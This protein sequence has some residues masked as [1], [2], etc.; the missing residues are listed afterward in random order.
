MAN[1][2]VA[3]MGVA[4]LGVERLA[5]WGSTLPTDLKPTPVG[6]VMVTSPPHAR[7]HKT[8]CP[9]HCPV[10]QGV[11]S[12]GLSGE[13]CG[14]VATRRGTCGH[15]QPPAA[16][17][18]RPPLGRGGGGLSHS[19]DSTPATHTE[20]LTAHIHA[21]GRRCIITRAL[22]S[23]VP[24]HSPRPAYSLLR[25][26]QIPKQV[27]AECTQSRHI[28]PMHSRWSPA[29]VC[30]CP[31]PHRS[32]P[33]AR[34]PRRARQAQSRECSERRTICFCCRACCTTGC[35]AGPTRRRGTLTTGT[36][37]CPAIFLHPHARL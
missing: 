19:T 9:Y 27:S 14:Y 18:P 20:S 12:A 24:R 11:S 6:H 37:V 23:I 34:A 36:L 28:A 16:P 26:P 29:V 25:N 7:S 10:C 15:L 33:T 32:A 13:P 21:C 22:T 8:S 17:W 31:S 5:C 1:L 30:V 35:C 4:I 2:G 3:V